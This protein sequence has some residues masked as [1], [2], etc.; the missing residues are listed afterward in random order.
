MDRQLATS[1]FLHSFTRRAFHR[2]SDGHHETVTSLLAGV[3]AG[4]WLT[5]ILLLTIA[6]TRVRRR[7]FEWVGLIRHV[8]N[9]NSV[10]NVVVQFFT[11]ARGGITVQI[12]TNLVSNR[13]A[14]FI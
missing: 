10:V 11:T 6:I 5:A 2:G 13:L 9:Y 4:F 7:V 3:L 1:S 12:T 8:T 14:V